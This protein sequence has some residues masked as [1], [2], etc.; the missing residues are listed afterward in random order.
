MR[1]GDRAFPIYCAAMPYTRTVI[2]F[3]VA[4][5]L[6]ACSQPPTRLPLTS[7]PTPTKV[8]IGV[9]ANTADGGIFVAEDRGYFKDE[10]I[11]LEVQRF[12]TLVDMV[13][14]LTSGQLQIA[15][16]ALAASLFIAA[17]RGVAIRVVADKGQTPSPE[18]DYQALVI[19]KD[20]IESGSVTEYRDL[21]DLRLVTSGRGNSTEVVLATAL[22]KGGLTLQ[23][24]NFGQMGFSD[25]VAAFAS[26][27]IDGGI[28]VEPFV[29]RVV[30][31]RTGVRWKSTLH[32][33]GRK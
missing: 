23:D 30:S 6:S 10:G 32:V 11:D 17:A 22:G 2:L 8:T 3:M 7:T 5:M 15:S 27:S 19:R 31:D 14:P 1:V 26:K 28:V 12:Q 29:S 13:A 21:K 33:L 20:L 4:G 18:W 9:V 25:M 24:V 16:G